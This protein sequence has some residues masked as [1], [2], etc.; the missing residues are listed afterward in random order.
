M[1]KSQ[2]GRCQHRYV[3]AIATETTKDISGESV[4]HSGHRHYEDSIP[5]A[6]IFD[7]EQYCFL[8]EAK[9]GGNPLNDK[10]IRSHAMGWL[11][12]SED[13][14]ES[15]ILSVSWVDVVEAAYQT[16]K[17]LTTMND[18]ECY[19][20]VALIEYLS[21]AHYR[22]RFAGFDLASLS[23]PP[24]L[25]LTERVSFGL[26]LTGLGGS[27]GFQLKHFL[28]RERSMDNQTR[29]V[30]NIQWFNQFF[31][32]VYRLFQRI[33]AALLKEMALPD[34]GFYYARPNN[35]PQIPPYYVVGIGGDD[36]FAVQV[37]LILNT[38]LLENQPAFKPEVSFIVVKHP[39]GGDYLR[40]QG[41]GERV[42]ANQIEQASIIESAGATQILSGRIGQAET[43]RHAIPGFSS[44]DRDICYW[45]RY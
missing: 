24:S 13:E 6:W 10:Q 44:T 8:V 9:I 28:G 25:R 45:S 38:A 5:D 43:K 27:P 11:K 17:H 40:L 39:A 7:A 14:L 35:L 34:S 23:A 18:Q 33:A 41:Y 2:A 22:R 15:H 31:N 16:L 37:F 30:D 19:I 29:L 21:Y 3:L 12:L 4:D 1:D 32:D 20:F 42:L 26:N 36:T